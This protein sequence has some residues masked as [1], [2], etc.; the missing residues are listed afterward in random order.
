M[1][2]FLEK[3]ELDLM[4]SKLQSYEPLLV[5]GFGSKAENRERADS[6]LDIAYLCR[7]DVADI[8]NFN[9]AQL[10]AEKVGREVDLIQLKKASTVLKSQILKNGVLL[11]SKG[12]KIQHEFEMY[13]L[14]DY[15]RLNEERKPILDRIKK[16]GTVYGL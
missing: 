13:A 3:D 14:S 1:V 5:Y 12:K 6:D 9:L 11:F 16:E 4:L 10:L 8:D 15:A 2:S 7:Q